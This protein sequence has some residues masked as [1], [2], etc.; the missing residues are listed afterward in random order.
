MSN[1]ISLGISKLKI[2][3]PALQPGES[4]ADWMSRCVPMLLQ[5]G[6]T[7]EEAAGQC[8]G[9]F[10]QKRDTVEFTETS[11]R[12]FT[13]ETYTAPEDFELCGV[14]IKKGQEL[15]QVLGVVLEPETVDATTTEITE[16]DIYSAEEIQKACWDFNTNF[17]KDGNDF[18]HNGKNDP[19]VIILESYVTPAVMKINGGEI[20]EGT[21]LMRSL[22][23]NKSKWE[24]IKG[25]E[26]TGY[27]IG[28]IARGKVEA[29]V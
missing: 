24:A 28:G 6:K 22:V 5:E 4:Q 13:L 14:T 8:L 2:Q 3:K 27:S 29:A 19:H 11:T 10:T 17:Q 23:L 12:K 1:K 26:I 25:G 21:W 15:H 20:N 16:G 7:Q 9:M 18:M